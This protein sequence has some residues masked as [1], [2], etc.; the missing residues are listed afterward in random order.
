MLTGSSEYLERIHFTDVLIAIFNQSVSNR[1]Y[2]KGKV[3]DGNQIVS[4]YIAVLSVFLVTF[5]C[6][7]C[8][9]LSGWSLSMETS[10]NSEI[11]EIPIPKIPSADNVLQSERHVPMYRIKFSADHVSIGN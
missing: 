6:Y 4:S 8:V 2:T 10:N 5:K 11:V 1:H 9:V 3:T 7:R